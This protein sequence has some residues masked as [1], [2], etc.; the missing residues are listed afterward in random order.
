MNNGFD[1]ALWSDYFL[2]TAG[3]GAALA[4]LV[5]VAFS[6]N[7]RPI[8]AAPGVVGRGAE[9]LMLLVSPVFVAIVGLWPLDTV[10]RIGIAIA[11]VG[12]LLWLG[13]TLI[14]L[15]SMRGPSPV[16]GSRRVARFLLAQAGTLPIIV[17]G[18]SLA[19]GTG[20]GLDYLPVGAL[21]AIAGGLIGAWVLLVEILR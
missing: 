19:I 18:V 13:V 2:A 1:P 14:D 8:L 12:G 16:A 7:L 4:G 5:F 15:R 9:A 17:A 3:V 10:A 6:L 11:V 20:L 21:A